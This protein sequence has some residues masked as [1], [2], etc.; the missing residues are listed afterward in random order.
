MNNRRMS[1]LLAL[2]VL[3]ALVRWLFPPG[4]ENPVATSAAVVRASAQ[5]APA[6][7]SP[8]RSLAPANRTEPGEP[9]VPGDA[10]AVRAPPAP[11]PAPPAPKVQVVVLPP[12]APAA[13][14]APPPP[15]PPFQ[16][17]GT[18]D[19]GQAL[20]VFVSSPNG[21]LL[22]R[23]GTMLLA[24]YRVT[25][26]TLQTLSLTHVPSRRELTLPVPGGAKP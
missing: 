1:W 7:S 6:A 13:I 15:P 14:V 26:V 12:P 18:W 19:D 21:T 16:V 4:A 22:A 3:L 2:M 25:A 5:P 20:G 11:P 8:A 24:E 23:P 10:F 17:I 9:D